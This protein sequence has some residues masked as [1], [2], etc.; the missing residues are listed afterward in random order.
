MVGCKYI[1][2]VLRSIVNGYSNGTPNGIR[3]DPGSGL[4]Y[5]PSHFTWMD[6]NFPAGS[7]RQGYPIEIQALWFA[8]LSFMGE[9]DDSQDWAARARRVS[10]SIL[11][12]FSGHAWPY[13]S[14]CLLATPGTPAHQ[15]VPDDALRPNQLF[16]IT[17]GAISDNRIAPAILDATSRLLVPGGIRS[18]A[19]Q[20]VQIPLPIHRDGVL[21]ND[22]AHPY[23]GTY[24]GDEDTSRK[25]AYHN[26]TVWTWPFASYSEALFRVY[27]D[28]ARASALSLLGSSRQLLQDGCW[29][30]LPEILDGDAPHAQRGC[31][32]QAWS[33]TELLRVRKLLED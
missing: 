20:P 31:G 29:G 1:G 30:H 15:A 10:E 12:C 11:T 2:D 9:F 3:M 19:D 23:C 21:M 22:P 4:I 6:T 17:L 25:L 26:G 28:D 16:A 8:G 32:A 5:S 27:G 13:L 24:G 18:L 7:P 33:V 14:D